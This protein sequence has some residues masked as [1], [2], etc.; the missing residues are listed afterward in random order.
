MIFTNKNCTATV[1]LGRR[2]RRRMPY[3]SFRTKDYCL[4]RKIRERSMYP[5]L[6]LWLSRLPSHTAE[7]QLQIMDN[8]LLAVGLQCLVDLEQQRIR[9][10]DVIRRLASRQDAD[11]AD[12][13]RMMESETRN[14]EKL[15]EAH[16]KTCSL[17]ENFEK[18]EILHEQTDC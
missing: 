18:G 1:P 15:Q 8:K 16:R 4:C 11:H 10:R 5:A 2:F 12:M 6:R 7:S 13:I 3:E 17:L 9:H 14:L